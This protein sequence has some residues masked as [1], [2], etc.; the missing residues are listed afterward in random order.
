LL[1]LQFQGDGQWLRDFIW[2]HNVQ[3]YALEPLGHVRPL[4]YYLVNLPADLLPWTVLI[5]GALIYYYPWR[6]WRNDFPSTLLLCW[7]FIGLVFFSASKSKIAYYLVPILPCAALFAANYLEALMTGTQARGFHWRVTIGSL[8]GTLGTLLVAA[9]AAPA[10]AFKFDR[11][12]LIPAAVIAIIAVV[13]TVIMAL[14][15]A[16]AKLE[17]FFRSLIG[18]LTLLTLL[19]GAGVLPYLNKYKS[20]R[21]ISEYVKS[22]IPA[23]APV[24]VFHSTMADFN[25]Y[26]GR[27]VIP[28]VPSQS[29][30]AGIGVLHPD[31][32]L[33][34]DD[35]DLRG[36]RLS[37]EPPKPLTQHRVGDR[38][39]YL[40]KI[41][42]AQS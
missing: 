15:L 6:R 40:L 42:R 27:E 11:P 22:Q 14:Q 2:I 21:P 1:L 26:S 41:P 12:L 3:N 34:V 23:A 8:Y 29:A 33:L 7:F 9:F 20:P 32:Y 16:G 13:G 31:A 39:W 36:M 30:I 19:T 4:Y 35:K 10:V 18:L 5:P 38:T 17:L 28:V 25:Y 37:T 24:Y